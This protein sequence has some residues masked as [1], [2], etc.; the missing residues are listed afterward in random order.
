MEE[1]STKNKKTQSVSK[2]EKDKT[3]VKST[4]KNTENKKAT[5]KKSTSK[6]KSVT[7]K[8]PAKKTPAKKSKTSEKKNTKQVE[9]MKNI[10]ILGFHDLELNTYVYDN[11]KEPKA[12]VVIVHGM[13]EHALRYDNFCKF[14]NENGY[15][16]IATDSRGHGKTMKSSAEYGCGE[17]DIF[18]ETVKDQLNVIAYAHDTYHLPVYV[19]GHSYGSMITQNLVQQSPL[20]EKAVIC[21]TANGDAI[22]FKAGN[23][24]TALMLPFKN[25]NKRGGLV[26]KMC[27]NSYGKGFKDG[28]WLSRDEEVFETYKNDPLCGGTFPFSFYRSLVKNM[29]KTNAN[30]DK[31]GNKKLFLIAGTQDPVGE[32]GKQVQ[33][34]YKLYLKNNIDAKMKLYEGAR[35]E[36]LNEINK[37]EV[38]SDILNFFDGI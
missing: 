38:C 1:K 14:L 24:L 16:A 30:I 23:F 17:K 34:L 35:H 22:T 36:L 4:A 10:K 31:I 8:T 15:I 21:G 27:I 32:K 37:K 2:V 26:E 3:K 5:D 25:K 6:A 12:T 28:N 11:V 9:A 7:K 13:Q 29:V 19:F 20:I 33:K 18:A